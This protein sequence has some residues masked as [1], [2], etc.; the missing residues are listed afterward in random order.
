MDEYRSVWTC[1]SQRNCHSYCCLFC[2]PDNCA[3]PFFITCAGIGYFKFID[4]MGPITSS[5]R[6]VVLLHVITYSNNNKGAL[7]TYHV[8]RGSAKVIIPYTSLSISPAGLPRLAVHADYIVIY[9]VIL[10][11]QPRHK[12]ILLRIWV[13]MFKELTLYCYHL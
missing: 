5:D 3:P 13:S 8:V 9:I 11:F 6:S 4:S 1:C 2:N 7:D 10:S 12:L